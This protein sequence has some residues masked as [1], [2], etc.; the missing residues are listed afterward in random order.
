MSL[1]S[2]IESVLFKRNGP[3]S[4]EQLCEIMEV[5]KEEVLT[6]LDKLR[7]GLQGRG[8]TLLEYNEE[9]S[10]VTAKENSGLIEKMLKEEVDRNLGK[11]GL[12]TLSIILYK[13]PLSRREVD[14]IRGVNSTF[15]LRSLMIRGLVE[16]QNSRQHGSRQG[17]PLYQGTSELLSF[18]G[19]SKIDELPNFIQV[20]TEIE[21][22]TE[23]P[24]N[25]E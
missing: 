5:K 6:S 24:I 25:D 7:D 3:V 1:E 14:Y 10:F 18:L 22:I 20:R 8:I 21:S 2:Q 4:L 19:I 9:Y 16:R 15:I 13:G 11:A 12:E 23:Q 17:G